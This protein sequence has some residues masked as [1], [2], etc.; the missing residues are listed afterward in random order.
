MGQSVGSGNVGK[1]VDLSDGL[2]LFIFEH[3]RCFI[4]ILIESECEFDYILCIYFFMASSEALPHNSTELQHK[5]ARDSRPVYSNTVSGVIIL[6]P[7]GGQG[8]QTGPGGR[9]AGAPGQLSGHD[10]HW[11]LK[12]Y[13][14]AR[15]NTREGRHP[16]H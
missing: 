8:Q 14:S 3:H 4:L 7:P 13:F 5:V 2:P 15:R 9:A 1:I 12:T 11:L 10:Y 6:Y 16:L